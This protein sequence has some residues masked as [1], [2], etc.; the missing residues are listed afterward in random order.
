MGFRHHISIPDGII[1]SL[2]KKGVFFLQQTIQAWEGDIPIRKNSAEMGLDCRW[3]VTWDT[4]INLLR[5]QGICSLHDGD[6]LWWE[7]SCSHEGLR[8]KDIYSTLINQKPELEQDFWFGVFWKTDVTIKMIIFLWLVRHDK[9]LT[10]RNLQ[11]RGWQGPGLCFLCGSQEED[12]SHMF[13]SCPFACESIQLLC[14]RLH[15]QYPSY[16]ST[17]ECLRWW[18]QRG[19]HWWS[20]PIL[21]H[22]HNWCCRNK[23]IFEGCHNSPE[24]VVHKIYRDWNNMKNMGTP[25][26]DLSKRLHP[27][28]SHFPIGYFD[29]AAQRSNCG[30]GAWI[31]LS[32]GCHYKFFWNG[33]NGTNM[34]AKVLSLWGLMW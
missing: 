25:T 13:Y 24:D 29:G 33:G 27:Y 28:E 18:L 14:D 15:V 12:N 31:L 19:K 5:S 16:G 17:E 7:G 1:N 4:Y 23:K 32:P 6:R 9:N 8:V 20:L 30:C 34:K 11:I 10:W 21:F 2:N 3:G 26:K 22:W